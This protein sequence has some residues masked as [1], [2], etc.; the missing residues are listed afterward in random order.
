MSTVTLVKSV[1]A[2]KVHWGQ[3]LTRITGLVEQ[4]TAHLDTILEKGMRDAVK[5]LC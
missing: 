4:V 1:L 2:E 3:D 5:P